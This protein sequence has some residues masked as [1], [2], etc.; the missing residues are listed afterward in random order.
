MHVTLWA[1]E[2]M[3]EIHRQICAW[4]HMFYFDGVL[5]SSIRAVLVNLTLC[6][7]VI[8]VLTGTPEPVVSFTYVNL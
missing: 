5:T 2:A 7:K 1:H 4:Q 6:N 8:L 3:P